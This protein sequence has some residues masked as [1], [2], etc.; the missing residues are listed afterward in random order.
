MGYTVA[1]E[2]NWF[3]T[4]LKNR[5]LENLCD[6]Q[7]NIQPYIFK[8]GIF[9]EEAKR[10]AHE[11]VESFDNLYIAYSGGLDSEF[12]LKIFYE[13]GLPITPI[14]VDTPFN[15]YELGWAYNYCKNIG[16]KMR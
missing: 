16:K 15:Q 6:F 5:S 9:K 3:T 8:K 2:N 14:L 13:E 10:V 1:T 11:L 7:V 4:N 12:V